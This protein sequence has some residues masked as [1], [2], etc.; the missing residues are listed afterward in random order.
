MS[1]EEL[2][3]RNDKMQELVFPTIEASSKYYNTYMKIKYDKKFNTNIKKERFPIDSYVMTITER[4]NSK[5]EPRYEGPYRVV[6]R[7]KGGTYSLLDRDGHVLHRDYAP[8]QLKLISSDL[9]DDWFATG[10]VAD[11]LE[12]QEI[13]GANVYLV[14]WKNL[15]KDQTS[16]VPY[17]DFQD[18]TILQDYHKRILKQKRK[19]VA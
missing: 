2:Q 19:A 9:S 3:A 18:T 6:K 17:A 15:P 1:L 5:D 7:T 4:R 12:H 16:W 11:I 10:E 8:Q 13:D 14:Q